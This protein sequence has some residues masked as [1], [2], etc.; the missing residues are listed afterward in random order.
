LASESKLFS[1]GVEM[2]SATTSISVTCPNCAKVLRLSARPASG[3]KIKCP[4]CSEPFLPDL[5]DDDTAIQEKPSVKAK[6]ASNKSGG[7]KS[8]DQEDDSP[9]KKRQRDEDEDED[10]RPA[11]KK[12]KAKKAGGSM[13]L[14]ILL[15]LGGGFLV[16]TC[17]GVGLTAFVWP[18]FML[19]KAEKVAKN[20]VEI[21]DEKLLPVNNELAKQN[22]PPLAANNNLAS[23]VLPDANMALGSNLK[24]LRDNNQLEIFNGLIDQI[25]PGN[26]QNLPAESKEI[27]RECE[28]VL[29]SA[30]ISNLA[31]QMGPQPGP[32]PRIGPKGKGP[33][34]RPMG[35]PGP[36]I[37]NVPAVK[38]AVAALMTPESI[39]KIKRMPGLGAEEKLAGKYPL[40]RMNNNGKRLVMAIPSDRIVVMGELTDAELTAMLDAAAN[41]QAASN[42]LTKMSAVVQQSH[43][44]G[45][46]IVDPKTRQQ[47]QGLDQML[48]AQ[49]GVPPQAMQGIQA[50]QK[51]KGAGVAVDSVNGGGWKAQ[52][53]IDFE[54]GGSANT[55]KDA[56]EALK[57][58]ALDELAKPQL[59]PPP[60]P[61][62][63][64]DFNTLSIATQGTMVSAKV[65]VSAQS[66]AAA[67]EVM[68]GGGIAKNPPPNFDPNKDLARNDGFPKKDPPKFDGT[69]EVP[70]GGPKV[71]S[72]A[73]KS[74][75]V[76]KTA[77][78]PYTFQQGQRVTV[79]VSN[80]LTN[81]KT[82]VNL[83]V[84]R[85]NSGQAFAKDVRPPQMDANCR[86]EFIVPATDTYRIQIVNDGPGIVTS[87]IVTITVQ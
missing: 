63:I 14:I 73:A 75:F 77:E 35:G 42:P 32:G 79:T 25:M 74:L 3:K 38:A 61:S 44:W 76:G 78:R 7:K 15:L 16:L 24:G 66:V 21:K 49:P 70:K 1:D 58:L 9:P 30:N 10:D 43:F 6:S 53:H 82:D 4:A 86:V 29:V 33:K 37:P 19:G 17:G 13:L 56:A 28:Q 67:K 2:A 11:K 80:K 54:D 20:K 62:V 52:L 47:M 34:G 81:P 40:Y 84:F 68:G 85:G 50:M 23:Y 60:P 69:K 41:N 39:A 12:K 36:F 5:E 31:N 64:A 18:G 51:M 26:E 22:D 72:F 57:K 83:L 65:S 45:A 8:R 27:M 46:W 71:Q 87:S 59:G 55:A 48:A